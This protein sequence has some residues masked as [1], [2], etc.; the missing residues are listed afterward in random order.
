M[1]T[2]SCGAI[3]NVAQ[4]AY[5]GG[6][7][8]DTLSLG[9]TITENIVSNTAL[10]SPTGSYRAGLY[11]GA[12]SR[13]VTV[14]DNTFSGGLQSVVIENGRFHTL[15][16][17]IFYNPRTFAVLVEENLATYTGLVQSNTF[18]TNTIHAYNPDYSMVRID[19]RLD[20]NGTLATLSGNRY[21][22]LYKIK[23]PVIEL[24]RTAGDSKIYNKSNL[25][26][27]D[28]TGQNFTAFANYIYTSTG[29]YNG[30]QLLA[31]GNFGA[32]IS[33][34]STDVL[35]LSHNTSN[36]SLSVSQGSESIGTLS[37]N[38]FSVTNG[39]RYEI[40]GILKNTT[41]SE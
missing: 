33:S 37:S 9:A 22:N 2:S 26:D 14:S 7:T 24:M 21:L 23:S 13:G 6:Y 40:S 36:F 3:Q 10:G 17:N 28:L 34:W 16:N 41:N 8:Y 15:S 12:L 32:G 1:S 30:A 20:Q 29:S 5:A 31:N 27:I 25:T 4:D 11:L 35:T 18:S 19:D 38:S 39:A